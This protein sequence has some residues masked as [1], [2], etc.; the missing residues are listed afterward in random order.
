MCFFYSVSLWYVSMRSCELM[1]IMEYELV[2]KDM[3]IPVFKIDT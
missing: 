2:Y 3:Q 1:I